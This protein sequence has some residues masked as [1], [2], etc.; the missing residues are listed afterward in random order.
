VPEE[1]RLSEARENI[2][3]R[4]VF[5]VRH[6]QGQIGRIEPPVPE[7]IFRRAGIKYLFRE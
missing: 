7:L 3:Q 4:L 2:F 5:L 6:T 1:N